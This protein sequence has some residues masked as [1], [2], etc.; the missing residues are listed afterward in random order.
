MSGYKAPNLR[1]CSDIAWSFHTYS[2]FDTQDSIADSGIFLET[3]HLA[4]EVEQH[5]AGV[6]WLAERVSSGDLAWL[7]TTH[8]IAVHQAEYFDA[9]GTL[10]GGVLHQHVPRKR[11]V[12]VQVDTRPDHAMLAATSQGG[13]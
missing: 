5:I 6:S 3:P 1:A 8:H 12:P 7:Q 4:T 2:I 10:S 13:S 11:S 9:I